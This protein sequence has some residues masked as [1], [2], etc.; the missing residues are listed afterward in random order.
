MGATDSLYLSKAAQWESYYNLVEQQLGATATIINFGDQKNFGKVDATTG[1]GMKFSATGL[2]P[3]WTWSKAPSTFDTPFDL[4]L[5]SNWLGLAPILTLDGVDEE[6]DT[7]DNAFWTRDDT[8]SQKFSI[9]M[10][11]NVADATNSVLLSKF[12]ATGTLREWSLELDASDQLAAICYDESVTAFI[13][14]TDDAA[15]IERIW[16]HVVVTYSGST[17]PAGIDIYRDGALVAST[18]AD[19]QGRHICG[20]GGHGYGRG[21]RLQERHQDHL[22]GRQGARWPVGS[23][24]QP[25]RAD[26]RA[27]S[28]T[29]TLGSASVWGY[30]H[31]TKLGPPRCDGLRDRPVHD[32]IPWAGLRAGTLACPDAESGPI[33]SNAKQWKLRAPS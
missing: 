23:V 9:C 20:H 14:T 16:V 22:L 25:G 5:P 30:E 15:L 17:G 31:A 3:T 27:G 2:S 8:S 7:P 28:P 6:A 1:T 29:S 26:R 13:S 4:T 11:I 32:W 19:D 12:D 18:D 33:D 24:V 10:W 21:P